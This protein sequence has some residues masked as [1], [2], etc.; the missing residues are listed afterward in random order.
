MRAFEPFWVMIL[1]S[2]GNAKAAV[3][4]V[5]VL[6]MPMTSLPSRAEGIDW[7]WIGD[8]V[9]KPFALRLRCKFGCS[10]KSAKA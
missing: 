6:A 3:L 10:A 9:T 1:C 5:P 2:I 8:G 7:S 4:P